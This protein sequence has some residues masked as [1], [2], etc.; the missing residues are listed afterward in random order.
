MNIYLDVNWI[1]QPLLDFLGSM[2]VLEVEEKGCFLSGTQRKVT[3]AFTHIVLVQH[4][5]WILLGSIVDYII[6]SSERKSRWKNG[7]S[8][9]FSNMNLQIEL[10]IAGIELIL[11]TEIVK[12]DLAAKSLISAGGETFNYQILIVATG[13]TVR[14]LVDS[15]HVAFIVPICP[16][17]MLI[18]LFFRL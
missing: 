2:S 17:L 10:M 12:V 11:S 13:S 16:I 6:I 5:Y 3:L 7:S 8:Q 14:I 15:R 18:I 1:L 4:Y 9:Q